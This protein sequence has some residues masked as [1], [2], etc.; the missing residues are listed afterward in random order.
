M[1]S[2]GDANGKY[3]DVMSPGNLNHQ[4]FAYCP[5]LSQANCGI[6]DDTTSTD[7]TLLATNRGRKSISTN[8][9]KKVDGGQLER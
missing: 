6:S 7:T 1:P 8:D 5:G 4:M 9:M 3:A 2:V